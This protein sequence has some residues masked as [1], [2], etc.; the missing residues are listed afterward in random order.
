MKLY[1]VRMSASDL[2]GLQMDMMTLNVTQ[3]VRSRQL[4]KIRKELQ[5]SAKWLTEIVE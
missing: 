1:S 2:K 3:E 5:T 4:L